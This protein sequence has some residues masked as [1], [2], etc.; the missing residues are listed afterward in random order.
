MLPLLAAIAANAISQDSP[1]S[2]RY[3]LAMP[4]VA[5]FIALPLG[6]AVKWVREARPQF[7]RGRCGG[8]YCDGC[9]DGSGPELLF[10]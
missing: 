2:Q 4:L 1:A 6:Q 3:V 5:I 7:P 9:G 8:R 10:Q